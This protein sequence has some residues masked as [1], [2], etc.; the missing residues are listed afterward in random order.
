MVGCTVQTLKRLLVRGDLDALR[1]GREWAIPR[2]A[3]VASLNR[4][5]E[6]QASQRRAARQQVAAARQQVAAARPRRR[7]LLVLPEPVRQVRP[8]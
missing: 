6:S 3:F 4:Y 5:A 1:A 7:P 8:A 2:D